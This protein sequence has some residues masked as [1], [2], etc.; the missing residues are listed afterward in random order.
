MAIPLPNLNFNSADRTDANPINNGQSITPMQFATPW[1]QTKNYNNKSSGTSQ[2]ASASA[3][4][5][6]GGASNLPII[7]MLLAGIAYLLLR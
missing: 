6:S 4:P 7:P 3:N 5:S 1:N 2:S